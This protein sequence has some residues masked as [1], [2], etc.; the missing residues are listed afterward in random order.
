MKEAD[1]KGSVEKGREGWRVRAR[2]VN[3]GDDLDAEEE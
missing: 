3:S 1:A 2:G